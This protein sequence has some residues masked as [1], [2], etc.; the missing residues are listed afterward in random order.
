MCLGQELKESNYKI[1][2]INEDSL[3]DYEPQRPSMV[4][5]LRRGINMTPGKVVLGEIPVEQRNR[6]QGK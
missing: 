3:K 5:V 4:G 1:S 6:C 2:N